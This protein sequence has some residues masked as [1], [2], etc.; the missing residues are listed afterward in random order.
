MK[1]G[2]NMTNTQMAILLAT[3]WLAPHQ[4]PIVGQITGLIFIAVAAAI[5]MG[6]I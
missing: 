6:W 5:G 4:H 2:K 3:I 1:T